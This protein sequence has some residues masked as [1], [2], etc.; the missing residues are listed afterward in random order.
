MDIAQVD[1]ESRE[2][3]DQLE[4]LVKKLLKRIEDLESWKDRHPYEGHF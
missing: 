3:D 4:R 1:R 2:R